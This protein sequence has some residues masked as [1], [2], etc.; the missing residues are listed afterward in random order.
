MS[1]LW[2]ILVP[3][4]ILSGVALRRWTRV[5]ILIPATFLVW[6]GVAALACHA[7]FS[8]AA[9]IV[10]AFLGGACLQLGYLVGAFLLPF[11]DATMKKRPTT[12][13]RR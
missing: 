3:V 2:F 12:E 1:V 8:L 11:F 5:F 9:V 10:A 7:G 13:A 4:L 6:A